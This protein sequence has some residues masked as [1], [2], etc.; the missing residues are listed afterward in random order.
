[1]ADQTPAPAVPTDP[2]LT[3]EHRR[4]ILLRQ[5]LIHTCVGHPVATGLSILRL[6]SAA[7]RVHYWT[8][9]PR[10]R[11]R[12]SFDRVRFQHDSRLWSMDALWVPLASV[13]AAFGRYSLAAWL[14]CFGPTA[15]AK[16]LGACDYAAYSCNCPCGCLDSCFFPN[17]P[18][19]G[20]KMKKHDKM[21]ATELRKMADRARRIREIENE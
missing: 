14:W 15:V 2:H 10:A 9:P 8:L 4:Q 3:L 19:F 7:E 17:E 20:C 5:M 12:L 13:A 6:R 16:E 18:C 11:R 1:M 21:D